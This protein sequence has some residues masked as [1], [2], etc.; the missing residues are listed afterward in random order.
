MNYSGTIITSLIYLILMYVTAVVP[1]VSKKI[2]NNYKSTALLIISAN[3]APIRLHC[4]IMGHHYTTVVL[5]GIATTYGRQLKLM[6]A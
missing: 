3:S 1:L 2:N 6:C 4:L 5:L